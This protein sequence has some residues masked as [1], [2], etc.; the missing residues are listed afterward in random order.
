[1]NT[2]ALFKLSMCKFIYTHIVKD[3]KPSKSSRNCTVSKSYQML[4]GSHLTAEHSN[5]IDGVLEPETEQFYR[6]V[7][8]AYHVT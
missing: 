8:Y 3:I 4:M 5:P 1:M 6:K 2:P 7:K